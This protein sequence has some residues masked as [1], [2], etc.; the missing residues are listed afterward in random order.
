MREHLR[1][2]VIDNQRASSPTPLAL[3]S[4]L[5]ATMASADSSLRVTTLAFQPSGE[6]SPGENAIL[7]RTT[8]GF[9][10]SRF[11]HE[12]FAVCCPIALLGTASYPVL[13]PQGGTEVSIGSRFRSTLPSH[14]RSS[15]CRCASLR[16]LWPTYGRTLTSKIAPML[17]AQQKNRELESPGFLSDRMDRQSA[18]CPLQLRCRL[19]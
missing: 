16:L 18:L 7:P 2:S 12:S 13:P 9:T 11:D 10:P 19:A 14:T 6:G 8:A 5:A 15:S 17:G 4:V 1:L 3:R